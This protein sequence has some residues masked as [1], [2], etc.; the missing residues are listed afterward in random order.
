M[1]KK[2]VLK[3]IKAGDISLEDVDKKLQASHLKVVYMAKRI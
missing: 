1:D 2:E 3:K